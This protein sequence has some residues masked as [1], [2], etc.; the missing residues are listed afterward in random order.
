[1]TKV[2]DDV[3][4]KVARQQADVF[5]RV[6]NG[7]L[8]PERF[9]RV[10]RQ[11]LNIFLVAIVHRKWAEAVEAGK[12]DSQYNYI[13][14]EFTEADLPLLDEAEVGCE[15]SLRQKDED[16]DRTTQAWQDGLDN[17]PASKD[18]FAHPLKVLA[19]GYDEATK[20]EQRNDPIFTVWASPR[21][22]LL[23]DLILRGG[24]GRRYLFVDRGGPGGKWYADY[25]A[26]VVVKSLKPSVK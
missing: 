22:G 11:L 7:G 18:R 16:E 23:W 19:I 9:F 4:G 10:I 2:A 15:V 14:P 8:S 25:R 6:C 20:D 17:N 26:A 24:A 21:T 1:M 12:Y 13:N 3:L 5:V